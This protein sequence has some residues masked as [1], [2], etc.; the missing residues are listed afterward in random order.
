MAIYDKH[1]DGYRIFVGDLARQATRFDVEY[2]FGRYGKLIDVWVARYNLV[3]RR[4]TNA[5]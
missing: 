1:F 5:Q 4:I 3:H 2:E